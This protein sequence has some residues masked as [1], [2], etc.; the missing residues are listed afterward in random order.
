MHTY[1]H[2][3]CHTC[4]KNIQ[5]TVVGKRKGKSKNGKSKIKS[6]TKESSDQNSLKWSLIYTT[7][8]A[9]IYLRHE[10][11]FCRSPHQI[12]SRHHMMCHVAGVEPCWM[13][14]LVLGV[15]GKRGMSLG[16]ADLG[17]LEWVFLACPAH[18]HQYLSHQA[19][20]CVCVCVCVC[21]QHASTCMLYM[22][23]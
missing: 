22:C 3:L 1:V 10:A 13:D 2:I 20:M 11:A 4:N 19:P 7:H 9:S 5:N 14:V 23:A 12:T 8:L 17:H 21:N 6:K 15:E 18:I 16:M